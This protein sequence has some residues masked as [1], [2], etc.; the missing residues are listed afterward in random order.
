MIE[1]FRVHSYYGLTPPGVFS[2]CSNDE[3]LM[4]DPGKINTKSQNANGN[5]KFI[6]FMSLRLFCGGFSQTQASGIIWR[7]W[8]QNIHFLKGNQQFA[9]TSV[10]DKSVFLL[11]WPQANQP[12][13]S[14]I[15]P[16][17]EEIMSVVGNSNNKVGCTKF[18]AT[19]EFI[20]THI[21]WWLSAGTLYSY[22]L[23]VIEHSDF[24]LSSCSMNFHLSSLITIIQTY[25]LMIINYEEH[26][27]T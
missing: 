13:K 19:L 27:F 26:F 7:W 24:R 9:E 6:R 17:L 3:D 16:V 5:L 11:T 8:C 4:S 2:S 15:S 18:L 22:S 14:R 12:T 21:C 1:I 25:E 10:V 23:I 20:H